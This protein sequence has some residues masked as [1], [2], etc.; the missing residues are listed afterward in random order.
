MWLHISFDT[1]LSNIW[2][3]FIP[4]ENGVMPFCHWWMTA[5]AEYIAVP[6]KKH[7]NVIVLSPSD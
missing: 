7:Y 5:T 4:L 6:N 1:S 3:E 2:Y